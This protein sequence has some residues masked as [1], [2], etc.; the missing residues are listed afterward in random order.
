M[1]CPK[2]GLKIP[3][4]SVFC[5][6][7]GVKIDSGEATYVPIQ[8]RTMETAQ[9]SKEKKGTFWNVLIVVLSAAIIV[10][11][12]ISFVKKGKDENDNFN[13]GDICDAE[14]TYAADVLNDT[15]TANATQMLTDTGTAN[16][17]NVSND[18]EASDDTYVAY[19]TEGIEGIEDIPDGYTLEEM[20]AIASKLSMEEIANAE[21]FGWFLD[22]EAGLQTG[23]GDFIR[24]GEAVRITSDQNPLLNGGWSAFMVD[25]I[26]KPFDPITERFLTA[27]ITTDGETF[28]MTLKCDTLFFPHE[29]TSYEESDV[30]EL[31]GTWDPATGTASVRSDYLRAEFDNFYIT[32]DES[33]EVATGTFYWNSGEV[34]RIA[35][36]RY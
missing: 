9:E 34:E 36:M 30:Y 12:V 28:D 7:C 10:V 18:T 2:C 4:D 24:N 23:E 32:E 14:N 20:K 29:G 8:S 3:D 27:Y 31:S 26:S 5:P 19:D 22:L 11:L 13:P 35:L 15:D 6:E 33:A 21:E 1:V 17:T 25:T 16:D